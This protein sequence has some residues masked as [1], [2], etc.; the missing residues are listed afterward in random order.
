MRDCG[1]GR[2][3]AEAVACRRAE[4]REA[5]AVADQA[6]ESERCSRARV[7]VLSVSSEE[8]KGERRIESQ[9]ARPPKR[10]LYYVPSLRVTRIVMH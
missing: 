2:G 7:E 10:G 6:A 1:V 9:V 8:K 5:L 3:K 4:S